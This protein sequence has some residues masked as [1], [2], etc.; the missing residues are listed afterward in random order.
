MRWFALGMLFPMACAPPAPRDVGNPTL[1]IAGSHTVMSHLMPMLT[2]THQRTVGTTDFDL[3]GGG[4]GVGLRAMLAGEVDIAAASRRHIPAEEEQAHANGYSLTEPGARH[5]VA[6][7]V[8]ALSVHPSNPMESLTYDQV[9]GI[10]C[11]RSIDNWSFLGLEDRPIRPLTL[12]PLAGSRALFEDFFCGPRGI[13]SH[14]EILSQE[15]INEALRTDPN[16]IAYLSMAEVSGKVIGLRPDVAGQALMPSQQNI[17]RGAYPLY[18]DLYLYTPGPARGTSLSFLTWI[19]S[20]AGQ[21]VVDEARFVPLFLRPEQLDEPRPL[22][23][24]IHFEPGSSVPNQRSTARI[25]LLVAEL[26]DRVGEF[27]HVVLE[28]YTDN[29]EPDPTDLSLARAEAVKVIL[30]AELPGMFFE[31]IPRGASNPIAPNETPY[32]RLRNRRVQIY[33]AEEEQAR[34]EIV[35]EETENLGG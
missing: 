15:A 29:Q 12:E 28:G 10:W 17:I 35:P 1:R 11:T 5:I 4:T 18:H 24:T 33:L 27:R 3:Q 16:A 6:V 9:I 7:D 8:L 32:G 22:R 13:H 21:E 31:I 26:T 30:E 23:E 14:V 25:K 19:A 2:D 34:S 20:P